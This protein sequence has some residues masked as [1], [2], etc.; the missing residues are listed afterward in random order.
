M[1]HTQ[2]MEHRWG[3]RFDL[4]APAEIRNT[5]GGTARVI[6]RNASLSGAYVETRSQFPLL[7]RVL[8]R[9][10]SQAA[11]WMEGCVVRADHRGVGVEWIEAEESALVALLT[12]PRERPGRL[13]A[14]GNEPHRDP[15]ESHP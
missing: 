10:L 9:P 7:A 11:A 13:P 6:V 1:A 2:F 8:L 4:C 3:S 12:L 14:P 5:Q 15:I